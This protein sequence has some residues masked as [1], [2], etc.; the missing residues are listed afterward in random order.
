MRRMKMMTPRKMRMMTPMKIKMMTQMIMRMMAPRTTKTLIMMNMKNGILP[1][2]V[3]AP[4]KILL[5]VSHHKKKTI[6][7][8][9]CI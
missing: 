9:K 7:E 5:W 4:I 2:K 1:I 3:M 8:P 6:L